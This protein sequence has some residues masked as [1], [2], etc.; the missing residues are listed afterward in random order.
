CCVY[1]TGADVDGADESY[2]KAYSMEGEWVTTPEEMEAYLEKCLTETGMAMFADA[3]RRE[4][5][6]GKAAYMSMGTDVI[7][8]T[9]ACKSVMQQKKDGSLVMTM[10]QKQPVSCYG[11][12]FLSA[13]WVDASYAGSFVGIR[14]FNQNDS[15][16]SGGESFAYRNPDYNHYNHSC[17]ALFVNQYRF[18]DE[19]SAAFY[20]ASSGGGSVEF[21]SFTK[22]CEIAFDPNDMPFSEDYTKEYG[23][24][25]DID[26]SGNVPWSATT[27]VNDRFKIVWEETF[28]RVEYETG[29]N[30]YSEIIEY[31]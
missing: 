15:I 17:A 19:G 14:T 13:L 4:D 27:Y 20:W 1:E 29:G 12:S 16:P 23:P 28:V 6:N 8:S 22:V 31:Q 11:G 9:H 5:F 2:T 24:D 3:F 30:W 21:G 25:Y 10:T 7:G 18:G 26:A